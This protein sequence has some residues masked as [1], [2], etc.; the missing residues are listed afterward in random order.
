MVKHHFTQT[1][2]KLLLS[3]LSFST[4]DAR[5]DCPL[6]NS[7]RFFK[8]IRIYSP[9]KG[10]LQVHVIKVIRNLVPIA[11]EKDK[12]KEVGVLE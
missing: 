3:I 10:L 8:T 7:R 1:P 6:L 9:E 4:F 2:Y 5:D 11:L 12:R